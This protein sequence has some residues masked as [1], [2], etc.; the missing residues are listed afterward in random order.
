VLE[1]NASA[2]SASVCR[3]GEEVANSVS[4]GVASLLAAAGLPVLIVSAARHGS[5][6]TIVGASVFGVTM[7][8]LYLA[9]TLYHALPHSRAK[10]V[11]R[12][13]DHVAIFLLIAGTYT[14]FTLG[15]LRGTWGWTLLGLVWML[16]VA[17]I[18]MKLLAGPSFP[19]LSVGLYLLMGWLAVIAAG[20]LLEHVPKPGLAWLVAGGLSYTGGVAFYAAR[21]VP[22]AHFVWH[23]CV[24]AGSACHYV[25][26]LFYAA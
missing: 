10:R 12:L 5:A 11:W 9:S 19:V 3:H 8:A 24:M 23:L 25:A 22:Y 13:I 15:V 16:A 4:H 18:W 21:R 7:V 14:P 17:G 26:V 1:T 6:A 20:P 2:A